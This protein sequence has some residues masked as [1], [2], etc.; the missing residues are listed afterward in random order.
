MHLIRCGKLFM[1]NY[2]DYTYYR[3]CDFYKKKKDSSAEMT[4]AILVSIIQCF[5]LIDSFILVRIL[6]EY[7]IPESFSKYWFLPFYVLILLCNWYKYVK[8]KMYREFRKIWKD[9]NKLYR[10]RNGIYVMLFLLLSITIPIL[11]GIKK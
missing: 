8:S 2:F 4:G 1:M 9:E 3:F 11:Y 6:W 7:P 10:K 5:I